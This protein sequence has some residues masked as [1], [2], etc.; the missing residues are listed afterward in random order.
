[1]P[2][3]WVLT[4]RIR[5]VIGRREGVSEKQMFGGIGFLVNGNMCCGV[6]RTELMVRLDPKTTETAL[7]EAHTRV[8]DLTGRPIRGW[9]LV[10]SDGLATD[11]DVA[12]WV[13]R[14][15][16]FAKSLPRKRDA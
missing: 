15:F 8:F 13:N 7:G 3:D 9:I 16:Q 4:E 5:K 14:G 11:D 12:H 1:M 10:A 6:H 2:Y